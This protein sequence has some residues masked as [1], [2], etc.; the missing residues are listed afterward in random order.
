MLDTPHM[1]MHMQVIFVKGL[2]NNTMGPF[3]SLA[4]QVDTR[5]ALLRL[6]GDMYESTA[7]V[8]YHFYDRVSVGGFVIV[9]DWFGLPAKEACLDFFKA[10]SIQPTVV[11]IDKNAAYWRKT[12]HTEVQRWRYDTK[13]FK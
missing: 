6:D 2:F 3:A 12:E 10:H 1:H 4:A 7:D 8:L 5:L 13:E 11:P 9:D